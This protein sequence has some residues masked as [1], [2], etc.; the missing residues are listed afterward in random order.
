MPNRT[1]VTPLVAL[2]L[3]I[4]A[5]FSGG[6]IPSWSS[7][8]RTAGV[9]GIFLLAWDYY[10]WR[11]P[12]LYPKIVPNPNL[13]GTWKAVATIF[14]LPT[15]AT[16][17]VN[18]ATYE[19]VPVGFETVTGFVV[20]RQTGSG[21]KFTALWEDDKYTSIMKTFAPIAGYD[22]RGVFVGQ[23]ENK[24]GMTV[25][26]AGILIHTTADPNEARLYY[27]TIE[28][29]P[30]RGLLVLDNRVRQFCE[31]R[32]EARRLPLDSKRKFRQ[33]MKFLLWPW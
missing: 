10:L 27:T 15:P 23:Y 31:T 7:I 17:T 9:L 33:K 19:Q 5:L 30:Q 1:L 24:S 13:R 12:W 25:G 3:L 6:P 14:H 4:Y 28:P 29:V 18:P 11:V 26:V 22:G 2:I 21:I 20:F 32:D 8:N 16:T